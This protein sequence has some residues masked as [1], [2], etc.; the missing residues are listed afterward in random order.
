M[1]TSNWDNLSVEVWSTADQPNDDNS[2]PDDFT[3]GAYDHT[4]D[5][6][7]PSYV[8]GRHSLRVLLASYANAQMDNDEAAADAVARLRKLSAFAL[9]LA[10]GV[11][12]R[13]KE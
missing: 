5:E 3:V 4:I 12:R 8:G 11:E 13:M 10:N 6:K 7:E 2:P 9:D 1:G